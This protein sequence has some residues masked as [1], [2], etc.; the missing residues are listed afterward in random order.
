MNKRAIAFE[1]I[2]EDESQI[3]THPRTDLR[4]ASR[5]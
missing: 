5:T 4:G 1:D 3:Q 2:F